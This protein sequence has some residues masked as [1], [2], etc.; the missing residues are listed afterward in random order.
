VTSGFDSLASEFAAAAAWE[1]TML[2]VRVTLL[3]AL[4]AVAA[5]LVGRRSASAR[6]LVWATTLA[7]TLAL[8][9]LRAAGVRWTPRTFSA[10]VGSME[11]ADVSSIVSQ[12]PTLTNVTYGR[13][14]RTADGGARERAVKA[15]ASDL[16]LL[17]VLLWAAGVSVGLGTLLRDVSSQ[18]R[19]T[20]ASR[21]F[22]TASH[23]TPGVTDAAASVGAEVRELATQLGVHRPV[24]IVWGS[25][26]TMP[27]T[28]G[29]RRPVLLLP[30]DAAGWP[31]AA[32]D[33]V[34]RHELAHVRRGDAGWAM[35]A[36]LACVVLW[37]HPGMW[38][39]RAAR[40]RWQERAADALAVCSGAERH[41]Y[42][43]A[44]VEAARQ[45]VRA[46]GVSLAAAPTF[47]VHTGLVER[48]A[49]LTASDFVPDEGTRARRRTVLVSAAFGAL[50]LGAL[51]RAPTLSGNQPVEPSTVARPLTA[52][53]ERRSG[54]FVTADSPQRASASVADLQHALWRD[55]L[56]RRPGETVAASPGVTAPSARR[57]TAGTP[58]ASDA[59][60][61]IV[62]Q[63]AADGTVP[64]RQLRR[65]VAGREVT[66]V[67]TS[68]DATAYRVADEVHARLGGSLINYDRVG[69]S[70]AAL[71]DVLF[72][73][74]VEF[75]ARREPGA[76]ILVVTEPGLIL[77]FLR[78]ATGSVGS[79]AAN[80]QN[81]A[82]YAITVAPDGA[83]AVAPVTF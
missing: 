60:L 13:G 5:A 25:A 69:M 63:V 80:E 33:A 74:A 30:T 78:R 70:D 62:V 83:Y 16:S 4:A 51:D 23:G 11:G 76:A 32:R 52:R 54:D 12:R 75:A 37:F 22:G 38:L 47:A 17:L 15:P 28:W 1:L 14:V 72:D 3:L 68:D 58:P 41:T 53:P 20:R 64:V 55:A 48:L 71:A 44:L 59:P 19:L 27:K 31:S 2:A 61:V 6:H 56:P 39:A 49:A 29:V 8:P 7:G 79:N 50:A 26:G 18:W 73:N 65:A 10:W 43:A 45:L 21:K 67:Y 46:H 66:A 42:A 9:A 82:A 40:V 57:T 36:E 35:V 34:L 24:C 77:P 81:A